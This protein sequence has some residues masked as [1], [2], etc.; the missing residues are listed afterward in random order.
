LRRS[1]RR[2][3]SICAEARG[4]YAG[5]SQAKM[6][7]LLAQ[8]FY[9]AD[10]MQNW[11]CAA[12]RSHDVSIR[13]PYYDREL[14]DAMLAHDLLQPGK[15]ELRRVAAEL[16]PREMAYS[17]KLAQSAPMQ[18]WLSGPLNEFVVERFRSTDRL[19]EA[20][21][22]PRILPDLLGALRV[23]APGA[24][25][26]CWN[27]ISLLAWLDLRAAYAAESAA[28]FDRGILSEALA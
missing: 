26:T 1:I 4:D 27:M 17:Q 16:M 21:F 12:S 3:E 25:L 22:D 18:D 9:G 24:S 19:E 6:F 10:M 11:N 15:R 23:G 7:Q 5:F 14:F 8:R 13:A 28:P 2:R 20:G